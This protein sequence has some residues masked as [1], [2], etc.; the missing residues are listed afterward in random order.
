MSLTKEFKVGYQPVVKIEGFPVPLKVVRS[1]GNTLTVAIK[2]N[3]R[4]DAVFS[5]FCAVE[6]QDGYDTPITVRFE[7]LRGSI[8]ET[9]RLRQRIQT[10]LA[11]WISGS[12][13][14]PPLIEV[15]ITVPSQAKVISNSAFPA[16]SSVAST[17]SQEPPS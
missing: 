11:K 2:S 10:E 1:R 5:D 4:D 13:A 8:E 3:G 9:P 17:I 16:R 6:L 15:T 14:S 12:H 7:N